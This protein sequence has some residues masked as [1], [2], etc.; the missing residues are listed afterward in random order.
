MIGSL[1]KGKIFRFLKALILSFVDVFRKGFMYHSGALTYHFILSV[2]PLSLVLLNLLSLLPAVDPEKLRDFL[3][4][5]TPDYASKVVGELLEFRQKGKE[6]SILA[7][8]LSYFFSVGFV[9]Q[10]GRSFTFVTDGLMGAKGEIFYWFFMPA[11]LLVTVIVIFATLSLSIFLKFVL[12]LKVS[13]LLE[14]FYVTPIAVVS[15]LIYRSFAPKK[16]EDFVFTWASLTVAILF[17]LLQLAFSWYVV[18][19][20][21]K[22][23]LYGSLTTLIAFLLWV[24]FNFLILLLGARIIYRFKMLK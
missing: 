21:S 15:Y 5:V 20:F 10:L 18:N 17:Y 19:I 8:S 16:K 23:L 7:L 11:L 4:H 1:G 12:P 14:V 3:M 24:N 22:N 2:A 6:T 9:K 13:L